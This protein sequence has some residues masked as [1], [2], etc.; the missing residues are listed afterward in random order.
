M[1]YSIS[2]TAE[3]GD[4]TR[5][6]KIIGPEVKERMKEVLTSIQNGEFAREWIAEND[7]GRKR[8]EAARVEEAE[9]PIEKIGKELRSMMPWLQDT[10]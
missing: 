2:E 7:E 6:P 9:H 5:G 4:Y 10:V 8:F 1:R 3:Y